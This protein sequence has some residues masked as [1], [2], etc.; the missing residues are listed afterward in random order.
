VCYVCLHRNLNHVWSDC[1]IG[2]PRWRPKKIT[3][4]VIFPWFFGLTEEAEGEYVCD[5][6]R[7][8]EK[9][10]MLE[11]ERVVKEGTPEALT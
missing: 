9:T 11:G 6:W 4:I 10:V 1:R 7:G 2:P 5:F 8:R 3:E